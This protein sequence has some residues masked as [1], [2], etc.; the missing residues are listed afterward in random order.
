MCSVNLNDHYQ[1]IYKYYNYFDSGL[2]SEMTPT[3]VAHRQSRHFLRRCLR[4]HHRLVFST[5]HHRRS[6]LTTVQTCR[7]IRCSQWWEPHPLLAWDDSALCSR[8]WDNSPL[9]SRE[10]DDSVEQFVIVFSISVISCQGA[11]NSSSYGGEQFFV[12]T[13]NQNLSLQSTSKVWYSA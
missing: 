2:A 8:T 10:W 6:T 7:S 9:C 12:D 1:L 13:V 3:R 4:P 5:G 11:F